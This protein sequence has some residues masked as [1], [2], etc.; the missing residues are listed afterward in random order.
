[1]IKKVSKISK[2]II[3][4]RIFT[5]S[6]ETTKKRLIKYAQHIDQGTVINSNI[7]LYK[8]DKFSK[9]SSQAETINLYNISLC[10]WVIKEECHANITL[11]S[12]LRDKI[13]RKTQ[14]GSYDVHLK[15]A[16]NTEK[17]L[18]S[19]TLNSLK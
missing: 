18:D 11:L 12:V 10:V 6:E 14:Q 8:Q 19:N 16:N 4:R 17:N 2:K 7:T 13:R 5:H 15:D 3:W 1:M 9:N